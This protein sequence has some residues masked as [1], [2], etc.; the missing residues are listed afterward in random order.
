[1]HVLSHSR[2]IGRFGDVDVPL[3]ASLPVVGIYLAF[4]SVHEAK[5]KANQSKSTHDQRDCTYHAKG[6]IAKLFALVE[7]LHLKDHCNDKSSHATQS[8]TYYLRWILAA[9]LCMAPLR[10]IIELEITASS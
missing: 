9:R 4:G 10:T 7:V 2:D 1:M 3:N 5:L 6:E 8:L